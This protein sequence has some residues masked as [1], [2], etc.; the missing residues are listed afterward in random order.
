[1]YESK[2]FNN[3][4]EVSI[5]IYLLCK[6]SHKVTEVIYRRKKIM[7]SRGEVCIAY[8][9]LASKFGVTVKKIRTIIKNFEKAQNLALRRHKTINVYLIVKY[10]KYQSNDIGKGSEKAQ[11][12]ADR[13]NNYKLNI[14]NSIYTGKDNKYKKVIPMKKID[15]KSF[16]P[17]LKSLNK[18]LHE[19]KDEFQ[20]AFEHGGQWEYEQLVKKKLADQNE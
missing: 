13:T 12:R 9:D 1:V 14:N 10:D 15:I 7:L 8:R 3:F 11:E 6:A 20:R 19:N 17:K 16:K 2:D 18:T 4:L 5:F